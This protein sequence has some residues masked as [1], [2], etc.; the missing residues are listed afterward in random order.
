MNED[1]YSFNNQENIKLLAETLSKGK[2]CV[3]VTGAGLSVS[4]GITPYRYDPNAIWSNFIMDR[5]TRG[6]F[7]ADP[8]S[9]WNNFWLRTHE[10][11]E[12]M[13]A[14]PNAGHKA[15]TAI[16]KRCPNCRVVT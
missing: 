13:Q 8:S 10:K 14:R 9:W 2:R 5:G 3:F 11:K 6:C 7:K 1:M 4:S 12:F 15:I 16:L